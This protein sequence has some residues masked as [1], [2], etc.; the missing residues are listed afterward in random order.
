[1]AE[2]RDLKRTNVTIERDYEFG[3]ETSDEGAEIKEMGISQIAQPA[4]GTRSSDPVRI[5]LEVLE[6]CLAECV[7][8]HDPLRK[9]LIADW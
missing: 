3:K 4:R 9:A 7:M 6:V 1:M 5:D 8:H 2:A